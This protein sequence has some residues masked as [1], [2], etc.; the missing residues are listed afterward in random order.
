MRNVRSDKTALPNTL[1]VENVPGITIMGNFGQDR[2]FL[3]SSQDGQ[4]LARLRVVY[5]FIQK[6]DILM[7]GYL[8]CMCKGL[9]FVCYAPTRVNRQD[10]GV[11]NKGMEMRDVE[12]ERQGKKV[13]IVRGKTLFKVENTLK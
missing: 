13:L 9:P 4:V 3:H 5:V 10:T 11:G 12:N 2:T 1:H 7:L 6:I 8:R